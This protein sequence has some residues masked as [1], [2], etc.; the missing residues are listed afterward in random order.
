MLLVGSTIGAFVVVET[1][2]AECEVKADWRYDDGAAQAVSACAMANACLQYLFHMVGGTRSAVLQ[3]LA[4][5][6]PRQRNSSYS[7]GRI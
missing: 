7:T 5:R 3:T 2:P 6:P 1:I 4:F